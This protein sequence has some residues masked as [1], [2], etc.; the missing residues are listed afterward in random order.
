[1]DKKT[2]MMI[3]CLALDYDTLS[4]HQLMWGYINESEVFYTY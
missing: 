3:Y 2:N 4:L 1:M